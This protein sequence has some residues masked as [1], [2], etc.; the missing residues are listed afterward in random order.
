MARMNGLSKLSLVELKALKAQVEQA[1]IAREG[2][3][4]DEM[5]AE[6]EAMAVKSGFSLQELF[7]G[8]AKGRKGKPVAVKYR[9]AKDP[10]QT[11]T[12]RGRPPRWLAEAMKKGAKKESFLIK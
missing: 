11:W 3:E 2:V 12:G 5:R 4:R 9:N 1:I 6:I 8:A 7:G 10:S